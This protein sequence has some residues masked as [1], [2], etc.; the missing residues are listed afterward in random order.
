M[1]NNNAYIFYT[2][3]CI[4]YFI[5]VSKICIAELGEKKTLRTLTAFKIL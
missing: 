1:R 3:A 5:N 2:L 4:K